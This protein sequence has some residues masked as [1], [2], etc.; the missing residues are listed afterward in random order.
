M[1]PIAYGD[2]NLQL[3]LP[4]SQS[5]DIISYHMKIEDSVRNQ[6]VSIKKIRE[7]L[8]QPIG[9]PQLHELAA[10][11][12]SAV[13]LISD[14]TRL[15]PSPLLLPPLLQELAKGGIHDEDIDIIIALGL[16]RKHTEE[17]MRQLVGEEVFSRIRVHNHSSAAEDCIRI[18]VTSAGTPIE[19]NQLAVQA[20]LRIVTG[21]IEPHAM[22]GISG[23]VKA[24]VPGIASQCCIEHNHSLSLKVQ[25]H[26]GCM[27]NPVHQ[28]MEEAL[29]FMSVDFLLNVVV[30]H[31]RHILGATA[32]HVIA[33]HRAGA[34]I[35]IDHFLVPVNKSYDVV[36]VS[37]GGHPKDL[38]LYQA[39]KSLRNAASI[40]KPGGAILLVAECSEMFGNGIFQYWV[41][42]KKNREHMVSKLKQ[43]FVLGAH[44]VLH[45]DEVLSK[46][47]VYLYSSLPRP[48]VSLLGMEQVDDLQ[49]TY[50]QITAAGPAY[51]PEIAIMPYGS[52]TYPV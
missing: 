4:E 35:A 32:G 41:E 31:N 44:K 15:C 25:T 10:G 9:T 36:V 20:D 29:K 47:R 18:G 2:T 49:S 52:L 26:A 45:L 50:N 5:I 34:T 27:D 22:A 8:S 19:I 48:L 12:R 11:K 39:I 16:H 38:Q 14:G 23:G 17:E 37:P 1:F 42:T 7:A 6:D 13:I 30:D 51:T 3:C 21:N 43:Q 28:D 24:L 40:T 33:A 46:H